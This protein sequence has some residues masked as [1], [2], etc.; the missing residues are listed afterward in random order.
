MRRLKRAPRHRRVLEPTEGKH[1][2]V[3]PVTGA[4]LRILRVPPRG[5]KAIVIDRLFK[6]GMG[7]APAHV[8]LDCAETFRVLE[9]IADAQVDGLDQRLS[10][11][12]GRRTLHVAPGVAHVNPYNSDI[13]DLRVRVALAPVTEGAR[14]YVSTLAEVLRDGR[15]HDGDLP[16][17]LLAAIAET[18]GERTYLERLPFGLQRRVLLP[19]G[20]VLAG[21]QGYT[22]SLARERSPIRRDGAARTAK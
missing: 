20:T 15:D 12:D 13:V 10:A 16:L 7:R 22:V 6:P 17:A 9:G 21:T 2:I 14:S 8:H 1:F 11:V 4:G 19:L 18:T 5:S 3:S